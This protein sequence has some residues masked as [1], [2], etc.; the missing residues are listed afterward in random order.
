MRY[1][2]K[3]KNQKKILKMENS[4]FIDSKI[5]E[6]LKSLGGD[7][8]VKMVNL[9]LDQ[10]PLTINEM[11]LASGQGNIIKLTEEAHKFKNACLVLG[12]KYLGEVCK[13]IELKCKKNE[14][15]NINELISE[16]EKIYKQTVLELEKFK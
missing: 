3:I 8:L 10:S 1:Y 5:I 7:F 4:S 13:E 12:A 11:K 9:F 14:F 15:S 6:D 16:M 2:N